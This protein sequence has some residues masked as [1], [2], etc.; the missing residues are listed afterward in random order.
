MQTTLF[1]PTSL[2]KKMWTTLR[3]LIFY[4]IPISDLAT[5]LFIDKLMFKVIIRDKIIEAFS[6]AKFKLLVP[7][8]NLEGKFKF[9]RAVGLRKASW[10]IEAS[11]GKLVFSY[12]FNDRS[13]ALSI[14][15]MQKTLLL[16]S[17]NHHLPIYGT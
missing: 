12:S 4:H 14:S 7:T 5:L 1:P 8:L 9:S 16:R 11:T 2:R 17:H 3:D 15:N 13:I 10:N 6:V